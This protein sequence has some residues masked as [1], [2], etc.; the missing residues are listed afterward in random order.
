V[1]RFKLSNIINRNKINLFFARDTKKKFIIMGAVLFAILLIV[2]LAVIISNRV[3]YDAAK[4]P[5]KDKGII[6]IGLRGDLAGFAKKNEKS[7]AIE[8]YEADIAAEIVKRLFKEGIKVQYK[9]TNS[10]TGKVFLDTG[11]LDMSLAA[12]VSSDTESYL[13]YTN[14]YYTDAIVFYVKKGGITSADQLKGKK[15]GV[16]TSS[17]AGYNQKL[18][19]FFKDKNI[20]CTVVYYSSYPDAADALKF[21]SIDVFAGGSVLMQSYTADMVR[22]PGFVL[23]YGYCIAI[24]KNNKELKKALDQILG[25]MKNDGT[26]GRLEQKWKLEDFTK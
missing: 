26:L 7:G 19:Q 18:E 11:D 12:I 3:N 22:L 14:S 15:V 24:N 20:I 16:V 1:K 4:K 2:V 5:I 10:K 17:Y 9:E 13:A 25:D 8:G 23:P 6:S 21:G